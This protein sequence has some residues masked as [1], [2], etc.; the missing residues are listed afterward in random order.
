[1]S[2]RW[3]RHFKTRSYRPWL[4]VFVLL[5]VAGGSYLGWRHLHD[6]AAAKAAAAN[7]PPPAV[8][9]TVAAAEKADY[10]V[11]LQGLGNVQPFNTV[12]VKSRVDGEVIKIGF[13]QGEMVKQGDLIAQI[14]PRPYQAALDQAEAKKKQDETNLAN[15]RLDLAR[16]TDLAKQN[17]ATRQQLDTQTANVSGLESQIKGDDGV[18]DNARTQVAYTTITAPISGRT[19]FRLVDQ[20]NNVHASDTTGIVTIVQLQ[21]IAV[22][23]TAPE[24]NVVAINQALAKGDVQ[25]IAKSSDGTKTL[26]TGRLALVNNEVDQAAGTIRMKAS[27]DNKDNAL[28]PGLSV[29]TMLLVDTLKGVTVVPQNAVQHG[30]DGL[31]VYAVGADNKVD[32]KPVKVSQQD[33]SRAVVTAGVSPG[34]KIVVSGQSRL[35][36]GTLIKPTDAKPEDTSPSPAKPP[37]VAQTSSA[38]SSAKVQS[39]TAQPSAGTVPAAA[40]K[41]SP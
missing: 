8:P 6:E 10:P 37:E 21:P 16:Y 33:S 3:I 19:G 27:F 26:S 32:I 5:V 34:D 24:E 4:A 1:L 14:D 20:G 23:L 29:S 17:F 22:V 38:P 11:Y 39:P 40:P 41:P 30:P 15:A 13:K 12:T 35:Q 28:W 18:I 36:K 31:F 2:S 25:V 7:K 9:A